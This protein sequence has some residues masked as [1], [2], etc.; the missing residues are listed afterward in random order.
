MPKYTTEELWQAGEDALRKGTL[1]ASQAYGIPQSYVRRAIVVVRQFHH[2]GKDTMVQFPFETLYQ[3]ARYATRTSPEEAYA[4][5]QQGKSH[6]WFRARTSAL[7][8]ARVRVSMAKSTYAMYVEALDTWREHYKELFGYSPSDSRLFEA[9]MET[10]THLPGNTI[11]RILLVL[12]E[13]GHN[14]Q[15]AFVGGDEVDQA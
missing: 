13:H 10:C 12:F 2:L 1:Y 5:L 7:F 6:D 14:V 8:G 3:A 4:L 11:K 9:M 15:M